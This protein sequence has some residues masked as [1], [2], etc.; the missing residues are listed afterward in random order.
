VTL[1]GSPQVDYPR[2]R[3]LVFKAI[4]ENVGPEAGKLVDNEGDFENV[5]FSISMSYRVG[6]GLGDAVI[7][8]MILRGDRKGRR[9][10]L[11]YEWYAHSGNP[12]KVG[13]E[14]VAAYKKLLES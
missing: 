12:A 5:G 13:L 14:A 1:T 11:N 4:Q 10:W 7:Q 3:A 8:I 2:W 9:T 6:G